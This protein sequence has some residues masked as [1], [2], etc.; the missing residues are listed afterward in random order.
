VEAGHPW[1]TSGPDV[2]LLLQMT[3]IQKWHVSS[4]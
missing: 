2:R 3:L 1:D 4:A